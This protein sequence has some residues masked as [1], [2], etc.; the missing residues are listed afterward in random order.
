MV[1]G[2]PGDQAVLCDFERRL[3]HPGPATR[4]SAAHR[5]SID[6]VP[7]GGLADPPVDAASAKLARVASGPAVGG[8]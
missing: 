6:A 3:P 4:P 7:N 2:A 8:R 5:H 1:P